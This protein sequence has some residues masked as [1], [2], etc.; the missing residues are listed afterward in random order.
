MASEILQE[1]GNSHKEAAMDRLDHCVNKA[2][3]LSLLDF[4][5]ISSS[6]Y[7]GG[8][9]Y[10]LRDLAMELKDIKEEL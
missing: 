7:V 8:V 4:K 10:L 9:E 6:S 2:F 5:E 3:A 1:C